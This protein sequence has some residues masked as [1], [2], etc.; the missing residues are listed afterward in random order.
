MLMKWVQNLASVGMLTTRVHKNA[1]DITCLDLHQIWDK[2]LFD[3]E[4]VF[5]LDINES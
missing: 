2:F 1:P 4:L 5:H 3:S